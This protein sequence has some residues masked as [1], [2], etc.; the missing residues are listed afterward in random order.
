MEQYREELLKIGLELGEVVQVPYYECGVQAGIPTEC[1]DVHH[2]ECLAQRG[3]RRQ[4]DHHQQHIH[5]G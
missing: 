4:F 5:H 1:G 3:Q 2:R